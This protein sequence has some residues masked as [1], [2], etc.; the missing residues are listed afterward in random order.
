M[1]LTID[2]NPIGAD[3]I[4]KLEDWI[5]RMRIQ[6]WFGAFK[7]ELKKVDKNLPSRAQPRLK[8][9]VSRVIYRY[10]K[11][12]LLPRN[13]VEHTPAFFDSY[14][15]PAAPSFMFT[16]GDLQ[17]LGSRTLPTLWLVLGL[18]PLQASVI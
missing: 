10:F 14:V 12:V 1:K 4:L 7:E 3:M 16:D 17:A 15:D 2:Y 11:Y 9:V 5:E 6:L 8:Q 13:V 18:P